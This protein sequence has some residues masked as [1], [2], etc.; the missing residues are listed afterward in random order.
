MI[1]L[2][3]ITPVTATTA[4]ALSQDAPQA[5]TTNGVMYAIINSGADTA[6]AELGSTIEFE[7]NLW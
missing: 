2:A 5:A 6:E 1:R 4:E 3:V 7:L